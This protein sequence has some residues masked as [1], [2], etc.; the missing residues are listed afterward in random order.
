MMKQ[1]DR[2]I[3]FYEDGST[4]CTNDGTPWEAPRLGVQ[5]IAQSKDE[6]DCD[7]YFTNQFDQYYYEEKR[8]GWCEARDLLTV[9]QHL[10]RAR[11]PCIIFGSMVNNKTWFAT[12]K[13]AKTYCEAHHDWLVGTTD[14]RP[15]EKYL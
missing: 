12:H 10:L 1:G 8:G 13:A 14:E 4:F 15:A 9:M 5:S 11:F 2:W 6:K 7:W 3:I